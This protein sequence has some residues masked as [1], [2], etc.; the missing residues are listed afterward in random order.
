MSVAIGESSA[1]CSASDEAVAGAEAV[2]PVPARI[3]GK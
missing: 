2:L 3:S 1:E